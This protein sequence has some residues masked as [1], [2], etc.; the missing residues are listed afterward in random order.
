MSTPPPSPG[1]FA[2]V[3]ARL[4]PADV[5]L[6]VVQMGLQDGW[7]TPALLLHLAPRARPWPPVGLHRL[8]RVHAS[9][10]GQK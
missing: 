4:L 3:A 8:R 10:D 7:L 1:F 2:R 6:A 5:C 9:K